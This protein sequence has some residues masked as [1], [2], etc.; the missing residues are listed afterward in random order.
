MLILMQFKRSKVLR[1]N[2]YLLLVTP[3]APVG[4]KK[5]SVS[6]SPDEVVEDGGPLFG[7][8]HVGL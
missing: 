8:P 6:S 4:S 5:F 3:I 2:L 7:S 1:V